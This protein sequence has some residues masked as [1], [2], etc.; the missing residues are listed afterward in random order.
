M[1]RRFL[2]SLNHLAL[3]LLLGFFFAQPAHWETR[4]STH[5]CTTRKKGKES[6]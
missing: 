3:R 6:R 1:I 5:Q 4:G 2:E